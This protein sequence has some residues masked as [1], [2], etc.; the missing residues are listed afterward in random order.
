MHHVNTLLKIKNVQ[1]ITQKH[2]QPESH[3]H[4]Y[5]AVWRRYIYPVY[6][7]AYH[8]YLRYISTSV[9]LPDEFKQ[10]HNLLQLTLFE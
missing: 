4:C 7:M 1:E 5:K 10:K 2:Y 8:T 6:P 9:K 3:A